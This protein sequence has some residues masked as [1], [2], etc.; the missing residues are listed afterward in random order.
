LSKG[1]AEWIKV[2]QIDIGTV[3][4]YEGFLSVDRDLQRSLSIILLQ[5]KATFAGISSSVAEGSQAQDNHRDQSTES[6]E[7]GASL[8]IHRQYLRPTNRIQL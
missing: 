5:L 4:E 2:R 6:R 8:G 3:V 1:A 7:N